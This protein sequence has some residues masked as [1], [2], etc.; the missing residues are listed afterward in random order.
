MST[1]KKDLIRNITNGRVVERM[2]VKLVVFLWYLV[3]ALAEK[4]IR[5]RFFAVP[6]KKA[7]ESELS[8]LKSSQPFDI[9]VNNQKVQ[10]WRWGQGPAVILAHGWAGYGLQFSNF[11][12]PLIEQ[13]FSVFTFDNPGHGVSEGHTSSYFDF[14]DALAVLILHLEEEDIRGI[15]GHSLGAA[16]VINCLARDKNG[17]VMVLMAPAL[18]IKEALDEY[19]DLYHIPKPLY[20]KLIS[21]YEEKFG[22]SLEDEEPLKLLDHIK[23]KGLIIHDIN[24]R[25]LPFED[26]KKAAERFSNLTLHT[27]KDL[28]HK[29]ILTDQAIIAKAIQFLK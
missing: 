25:R 8:Y 15:I 1:E 2:I 14:C 24:D 23:S 10:C 7:T 16:A 21:Q 19:F 9:T 3:P 13:G 18:K 17:R 20:Q 11:I 28:G 26:S 27:T 12:N 5:H 22:H 4:I 29:R 6:K